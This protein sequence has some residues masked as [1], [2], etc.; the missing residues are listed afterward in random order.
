MVINLLQFHYTMLER[1]VPFYSSK[2]LSFQ[3]PTIPFDM[4]SS[5]NNSFSVCSFL[6]NE[7][8]HSQ[9][10]ERLKE[11]TPKEQKTAYNLLSVY[12]NSLNN[13]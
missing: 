8:R 9:I 1:V 2:I 11:C 5:N 12:L 13:H 4:G 6:V 7:N 10:M 3:G